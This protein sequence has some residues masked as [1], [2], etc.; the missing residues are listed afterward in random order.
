MG[1]SYSTK[2]KGV[3]Y[4]ELAEG[5]VTKLALDENKEVIGYQYLNLGKM[6]KDINEGVSAAE[7]A[8]KAT[9]T[10]G[11]FDEAVTTINPR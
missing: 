11:R 2:A 6:M 1:T 8:D 7:A 3:R 4:M 10:Y 5:Y 9:G